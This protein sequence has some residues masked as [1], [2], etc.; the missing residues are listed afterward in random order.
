MTDP[1]VERA[2]NIG[3]RNSTGRYRRSAKLCKTNDQADERFGSQEEMS[4]MVRIQDNGGKDQKKERMFAVI[5]LGGAAKAMAASTKSC[6][7]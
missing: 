4:G 6:L 1:K 3:M 5:S 2:T 7:W